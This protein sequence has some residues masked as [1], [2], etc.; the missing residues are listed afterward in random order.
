MAEGWKVTGQRQTIGQTADG[1]FGDVVE[2]TYTT[3]H[4]YTGRVQVPKAQYTADNVRRLIAAEVA[5][6]DAVHNL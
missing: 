1:A 5:T 2:V 6:I 3:D 4:G